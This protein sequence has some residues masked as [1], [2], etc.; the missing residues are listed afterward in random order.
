MLTAFG[1][2]FQRDVGRHGSGD[3]RATL[4]RFV[5]NIFPG[6]QLLF[7]LATLLAR[8]GLVARFKAGGVER[9][10]QHVPRL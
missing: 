9:R 7:V 8:G 5:Y 10:A 4:F 6:L 1:E 2:A 3:V